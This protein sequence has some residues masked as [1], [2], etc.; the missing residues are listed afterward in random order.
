MRRCHDVD[1][2]GNRLRR[3]MPGTVVAT[4]GD[5]AAHAVEFADVGGAIAV[6]TI[7]AHPLH[8]R[9]HPRGLR[10]RSVFAMHR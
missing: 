7:T 10:G 6:V 9:K 1:S 2:E 8:A 5:G 3:D 4:S